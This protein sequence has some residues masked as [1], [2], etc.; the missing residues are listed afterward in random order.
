MTL[1]ERLRRIDSGKIGRKEFW[2]DMRDI[3][4]DFP[5]EIA[6]LRD[7]TLNTLAACLPRTTCAASLIAW[8]CATPEEAER[9][10]EEA[11]AELANFHSRTRN[12]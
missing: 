2:A 10:I 9:E 11:I 4:R 1:Q 7:D 6:Q 3:E 12:E 5:L 8:T